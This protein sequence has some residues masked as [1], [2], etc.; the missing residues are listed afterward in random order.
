MLVSHIVHWLDDLQS[1][2]V[3][4]CAHLENI[5]FASDFFSHF[6]VLDLA[7]VEDFY[8]NF[9]PSDYMMRNYSRKVPI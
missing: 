4:V 7:F 1:N 2:N 9:E 8:S 5:Y 3:R 6:Q